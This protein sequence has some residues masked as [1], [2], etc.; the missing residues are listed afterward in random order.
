MRAED[1]SP[2][3]HLNSHAIRQSTPNL[4]PSSLVR[5][6]LASNLAMAIFD[7]HYRVIAVD[8][9]RLTIRGVCSGHVLV[10]KTD[11][12]TPLSQE[13]FPLGK[14]IALSDP[15]TARPN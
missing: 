2:S 14:L 7:E 1:A 15:S 11:P 12:Q 9:H 10:I 4:P 3:R 6:N 13:D 8:S 5:V